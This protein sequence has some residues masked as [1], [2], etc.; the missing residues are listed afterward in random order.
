MP[1]QQKTENEKFMWVRIRKWRD[2]P[3]EVV[4]FAIPAADYCA[5]A[6]QKKKG[7]H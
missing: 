7:A 4:V 3:L 5:H 1:V 2:V 6:L